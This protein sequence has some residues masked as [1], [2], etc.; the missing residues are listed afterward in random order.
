MVPNFSKLLV[1]R[2]SSKKYQVANKTRLIKPNKTRLIKPVRNFIGIGK[3]KTP[4]LKNRKAP[5]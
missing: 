2:G 4:I 3:E 5:I 1:D